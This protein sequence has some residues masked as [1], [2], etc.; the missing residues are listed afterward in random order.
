MACILL[1]DVPI[2]QA[3]EAECSSEFEELWDILKS[4]T[5]SGYITPNDLNQLHHHIHQSVGPILAE[6][7]VAGF[8]AV[9]KIYGDE[10][11]PEIDIV[12]DVHSQDSGVDEPPIRSVADF[13]CIYALEVLLATSPGIEAE[14]SSLF[15]AIADLI[16]VL[17]GEDAMA[18][19][20]LPVPI[21][22]APT[23]RVPDDGAMLAATISNEAA[24]DGAA[25]EFSTRAMLEHVLESEPS[26]QRLVPVIR[27]V[28]YDGKSLAEL[29][30]A[31]GRG[32]DRPLAGHGDRQRDSS[33][34]PEVFLILGLVMDLM[35]TPEQQTTVDFPIL[36]NLFTGFVSDPL[37]ADVSPYPQLASLHSP[38]QTASSS[39]ELL[40]PRPASSIVRIPPTNTDESPSP[41]FLPAM[42]DD[43]LRV[44]MLLVNGFAH[45][46]QGAEA[47]L[48]SQL[49]VLRSFVSASMLQPDASSPYD[50]NQSGAAIAS[51]REL[52][53]QHAQS[54]S[55]RLF[56]QLSD[57]QHP[58]MRARNSRPTD[59]DQTDSN[60]AEQTSSD[61][62][63]SAWLVEGN[64]GLHGIMPSTAAVIPAINTSG[65][66]LSRPLTAG[67]MEEEVLIDQAPAIATSATIFAPSAQTLSGDIT[68]AVARALAH[69]LAPP[70]NQFTRALN[71]ILIDLVSAA[72]A[73]AYG[74]SPTLAQENIDPFNDLNVSPQPSPEPGVIAIEITIN[75]GPD[76]IPPTPIYT[77]H[78]P[79]RIGYS[80]GEE[81]PPPEMPPDVPNGQDPMV[82][83]PVVPPYHDP[84]L[85]E[86]IITS[87]PATVSAGIPEANDLFMDD[88]LVG[89]TIPLLTEFFDT[90]SFDIEQSEQMRI[91][92]PNH[93]EGVYENDGVIGHTLRLD[94]G[95]FLGKEYSHLDVQITVNIPP[96][97]DFLF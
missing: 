9:L 80:D 94:A 93:E 37:I 82:S 18:G 7:M 45:Q 78:T 35:V 63:P 75:G 62:R 21:L 34:N 46:A 40:S 87:T 31:V 44:G 85:G 97:S 91:E 22:D 54:Q 48:P 10:D 38:A 27:A 52:I 12:V 72:L 96:S 83:D 67:L 1:T 26:K 76:S 17:D 74:V 2:I 29:L 55:Y 95:D 28:V 42:M 90:E 43:I 47:L 25:Y 64:N 66:N 77:P 89:G 61:T 6:E 70:T 56:A 39:Q 49:L 81:S 79:H 86:E 41:A 24:V 36:L 88:T 33:F 53:P 16:E 13:L 71:T 59:P 4:G 5:I 84:I 19:V 11:Y 14:S 15:V 51:N 58:L 23:I 65:P 50:Q 30:Q 3:L 32:S 68:T 73:A 20:E 57:S 8:R 92:Y 60:Q 69:Y